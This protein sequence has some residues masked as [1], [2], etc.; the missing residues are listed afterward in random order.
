MIMNELTIEPVNPR[1]EPISSTLVSESPF[2]M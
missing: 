2:A 1:Q